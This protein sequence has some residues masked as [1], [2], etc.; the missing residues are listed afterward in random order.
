MMP[1]GLSGSRT[2]S[3]GWRPPF[4]H[5]HN[6]YC[7]IRHSLHLFDTHVKLEPGIGFEPTMRLRNRLTK[8]LPSSTRATRQLLVGRLR[9]E[10]RS[11]G[12]KG[13]CSNRW[14]NIPKKWWNR[15][16]MIQHPPTYEVGALPTELRFQ[17]SCARVSNPVPLAYQASA[18]PF[19]LR[20]LTGVNDEPW[21]RIYWSHI[22]ALY[23]LSYVHHHSSS[24]KIQKKPAS[25]SGLFKN[26]YFSDFHI[27]LAHVSTPP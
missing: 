22:P 7:C 1:G 27:K 24:K 19:S 14:T 20:T 4:I 10:L 13:R 3:G 17:W 6:L 2:L 21:S 8:P 16:A 23:L 12:L 25:V 5:M 15:L 18:Y 9:F 11:S 26:L